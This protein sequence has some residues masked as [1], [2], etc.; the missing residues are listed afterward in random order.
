MKRITGELDNTDFIR[1]LTALDRK[2]QESVEFLLGGGAAMILAHNY[3]LTTFDMDAIPM[4]TV[5]SLGEI[6]RYV[7]IVA[8]EEKLPPSWLNPYFS[9]FI[10]VLPQD[11]KKRLK[12]V[13]AGN[14]L[15]VSAL[16][17]VDLLIL[18][19]F[20][21]REKDI[22]HARVLL[23]KLNDKEMNLVERHLQKLHDAN[24]PRAEQA[25]H[26]LDDVKEMLGL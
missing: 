24:I 7:K 6:D 26:F 5:L 4:H 25:I 13:F 21:G 1:A 17:R 15:K 22:G 9:S 10:Y 19:C 8:Q 16:G 3:P 11:Y 12:E 2:L 20:A 23:K 14:K 18:K